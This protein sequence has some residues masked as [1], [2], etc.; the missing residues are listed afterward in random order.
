ME[1]NEHLSELVRI[2]E[3]FRSICFRHFVSIEIKPCF[4]GHI[5]YCEDCFSWFPILSVFFLQ[6]GNNMYG[7]LL[8]SGLRRFSKQDKLCWKSAAQT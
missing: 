2:L 7:D 8:S 5:G 6:W 1:E 3:C 4:I